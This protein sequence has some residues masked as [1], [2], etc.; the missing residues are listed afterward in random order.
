MEKNYVGFVSEVSANPWA[1]KDSGQSVTLHSFR[2]E[3]ENIWFRTGTTDPEL[4]VGDCVRFTAK[5]QK[6]D[7]DTLLPAQA[8]EVEPAGKS[9]S[10]SATSA[11]ARKAASGSMSRNGYWEEK[12]RYD[13]AVRQPLIAYQSARRDAVDVVVAALE[14]DIL[15]LGQKK[16]DK[17]ELLCGYVDQVRDRFLKQ[18]E[19]VQEE[20][21]NE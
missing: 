4:S 16:A 7:L 21:E 6:V 1:D 10:P 2:I 11:P 12:D 20:L 13:K 9:E 8:Y 3:S 18:Y 15:T 14:A 5:R 19:E 17:L